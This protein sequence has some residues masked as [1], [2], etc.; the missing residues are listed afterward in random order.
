MSGIDGYTKLML[1]CDGA[2]ESIIFTDASA[3]GHTM[4]AQGNAQI[5]TAQKKFG[6][7]SGFFDG[8]GDYLTTPDSTD[9]AFGSSDFTIDAWVRF[10]DTG[11][12]NILVGRTTDANSY[13][14]WQLKTGINGSRFAD[15]NS[16]YNFDFETSPSFSIN[17]W[18]HVA[19][20]RSGN[21]FRMFV[22][23][24]QVGSTYNNSNA[25]VTR[26]VTFDVG[27]MT[28]NSAYV[29]HGWI[30]ELRISK[31]IARWISNFTPPTEAYTSVTNI[32]DTINVSDS[33]NISNTKQNINI[34]DTINV[35][36]SWNISA[37]TPIHYPTEI[38][39]DGDY[40]YS[41]TYTNPAQIIKYDI[42]IPG[43]P[44]KTVYDIIGQ[45]S[46]INF[47]LNTS[48]D[49]FYVECD[50]GKIVKISKAN[51]NNQTI[52]STGET[53]DFVIGE[54]LN[55]YLKTFASTDNTN[56]EIV[57]IDEATIESL[58]TDVRWSK[59]MTFVVSCIANTS[60][61]KTI[62][63]DIRYSKDISSTVSMDARWIKY[64]YDDISN[65]PIDYSDIQV[66][67][68][69]TD[70]SNTGV[71]LKSIVITHTKGTDSVASFTLYRKHDDLNNGCTIT[72]NNT[73][74]K[75]LKY[76]LLWMNRKTKDKM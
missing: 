70:I 15:Y 37:Y 19:I 51:L 14:Y 16:G 20:T 54:S 53:E 43:N 3:S 45:S 75:Q 66:I 10:T 34:N 4:T 49:Y 50:N 2:D 69:G 38:I 46:A 39:S 17:T 18:Y 26:T 7:A 30:D 13:F 42:S 31:G 74:V 55:T 32:D 56:G 52:I 72:N 35:S 58:N 44:N 40:L 6:S 29:M 73:V 23:G 22:D 60:L 41:V 63:L 62:N 9:W 48:N 36:D 68:N 76:R 1:H 12:R 61:G 65:Y 5:D 11:A 21:D 8:S 27:A 28:Q 47:S 71:D 67:V 25:F 59:Q 64:D 24:T 57:M 33:W